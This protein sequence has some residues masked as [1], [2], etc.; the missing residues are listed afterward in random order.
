MSPSA[1]PPP[2]SQATFC[3]RDR[4]YRG[5]WHGQ[6][7]QAD[8]YGW[9][10]SGGL[11]TY[12]AKHRPLAVYAPAARKTFFVW[13]GRPADWSAAGLDVPPG[14]P[15][16]DRTRFGA[17]QLLHCVSCYDHATG[18]VPRPVV[19]LDK[20]CGDPHDN[21]VLSIDGAGHLWIF[22][23]SHGEWTTPSFIHR[24]VEPYSID[25]FET[26]E[27]TLFAYPQPWWTAEHGCVFLHT[28]YR[29]GR[30][31]QVSR[32]A[33]GRTWSAPQPL[34]FVAKGHYQVS[35][36]GP[37]GRVGTL[38]NLHPE[39][40]GLDARTNLY[41]AE[42]ADGGRTWRTVDGAP[43]ALP[44]TAAENPALVH[45]Y[46]AE[47]LLVYLKDLAFDAAGRPVALYLTSRHHASGPRGE[48]RTW[49]VARWTGAQWRHHAVTTSD[50]NYDTG[51]LY[52]GESPWRLIAPTAPGPR[53]GNP[54]GEVVLWESDD[55]GVTWRS[56]R[57]LTRGSELSHTYVRRPVNAH[58]DFYAFWADGD[59]RAPSASRLYFCTREGTVYRLPER[60][61][62]ESA[63]PER[64]DPGGV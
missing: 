63:A 5:I 13:G 16:A 32:S 27:E 50:H 25:R 58:P 24:S 30:G 62:G 55:E 39:E 26:V 28:R 51:A 40:G 12:C 21:P 37:G 11:G 60:M 35:E 61:T 48:P 3:R 7:R 29:D 8:A 43:L 22:S 59:P 36:A 49:R 38:F 2:E 53:P 17:G 10:Y 44:L 15:Q 4:G 52:V 6:G 46:A 20:Y 14:T 34:A 41:Y 31:L 47:G 33:D 45:D 23:P 64:V 56:A 19:L 57:P 9:K 18:T 42:S 54:G 1:M